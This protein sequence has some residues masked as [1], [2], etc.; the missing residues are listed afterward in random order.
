MILFAFKLAENSN[1][2]FGL[3][4]KDVKGFALLLS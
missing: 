3:R 4:K 2:L 1:R